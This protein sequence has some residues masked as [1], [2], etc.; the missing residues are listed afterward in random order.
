MNVATRKDEEGLPQAAWLGR[1]WSLITRP[2][3]VYQF[4]FVTGLLLVLAYVTIPYMTKNSAHWTL[5]FVK[6]LGFAYVVAAILGF[7]IERY[8][9]LRHQQ[10][11]QKRLS[12]LEKQAEFLVT[13]INEGHKKNLASFGTQVAKDVIEA[14]YGTTVPKEVLRALARFV[15]Q[16]KRIRHTFNVTIELES[17]LKVREGQ[18]HQYQSDEDRARDSKLVVLTYTSEWTDENV[19]VDA[20]DM[21]VPVEI[22]KEGPDLAEIVGLQAFAA[23]DPALPKAAPW[24][25]VKSVAELRQAGL[26]AKEDLQTLRFTY[27]A[28]NVP[29]RGRASFLLRYVTVQDVDDEIIVTSVPPCVK[30]ELIVHPDPDLQINVT[31]IH[32]EVEQEIPAALTWRKG[33]RRWTLST[34]LLPS[35]GFVLSWKP[36][37]PSVNL[38]DQP[39]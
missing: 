9:Q 38:A 29:S 30:A 12:N 31:S 33:E 2:T 7:S 26:E 22:V 18:R 35:Q 23:R 25:D 6:E 19:T 17:L 24:C 32:S 34:A 20:M 16:A 37:L 28:R 39:A 27:L 5:V 11:E 13:L 3:Y 21:P 36:V 8:N 1:L 14:A 15:L 10:D 4:T